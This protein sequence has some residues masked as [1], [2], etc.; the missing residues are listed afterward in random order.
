MSDFPH[1]LDRMLSKFER[2]A[3]LVASDREALRELP[4]RLRTFEPH[5]YIVREGDR[6]TECCLL[7]DGYAI[8]QKTTAQGARQILGLHIPGDFV[9]LGASLLRQADHNIQALTRCEGAVIAADAI[10]AV[11]QAHPR[12]AKAMWVDTL[13]DAA[14]F[15]EW[16]LNIGRRPAK[17]RVAHVI[18]EFAKRLELAGL[19]NENGYEFPMTQEQ[20][21]DATGLSP[22]HVNRTL[23][24][25]SAE[26]L[27]ER[28]RRMIQIPDWQQLRKIADFSEMYLHLDQMAA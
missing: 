25:L 11:H 15:R 18:C 5:Q 13:I 22:V 2:R 26:G 24:I 19:A 12:V 23:K 17:A 20:L 21:G 6:L 16:I 1:I 14:I 10:D 8:R 28:N 27:I 4:F 3:P 7:V 9:D